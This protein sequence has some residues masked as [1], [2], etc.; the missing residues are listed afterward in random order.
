[1]WGE[2]WCCDHNNPC[3]QSDVDS[4]L[5]YEQEPADYGHLPKQ[6]HNYIIIVTYKCIGSTH[7]TR[8][9]D[10]LSQAIK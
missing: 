9:Q 7:D 6:T 5:E 3:L 8:S 10:I 4:D 2:W 1:M